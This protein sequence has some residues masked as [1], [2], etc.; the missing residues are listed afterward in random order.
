M[1]ADVVSREIK[2]CDL[3]R[4]EA[5]KLQAIMERAASGTLRPPDVKHLGDG[6]LELRFE[7]E[8]RIFR[9]FY[10]EV[11]SDGPVLLALKFINKKSTQG[12]ATRS[13]D[14]EVARK[15]LT[16]WTTRRRS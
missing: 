8:R 3:K 9:L 6:L 13:E 2:K 15:R 14:I 11:D 7:G 12:I 10:S 4:F 1:G 5:A 16:E